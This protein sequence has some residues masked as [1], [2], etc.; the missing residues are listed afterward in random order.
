MHRHERL[1]F[2]ATKKGMAAAARVQAKRRGQGE[3]H[4]YVL[5]AFFLEAGQVVL[6]AV[7]CGPALDVP[8]CAGGWMTATF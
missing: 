6:R 4:R 7:E 3:D 2:L 5:G 8:H 1:K